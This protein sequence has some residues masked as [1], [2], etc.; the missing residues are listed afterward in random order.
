MRHMY[1]R[2][3]LISISLMLGAVA[4]GAGENPPLQPARAAWVD[5]ARVTA[6]ESEPGS[7]LVHGRTW[8]EQRFSPLDQIDRS[9]VQELGLAWAYMTGTLRGLEAT[10]LAVDGVLYLT[11]SWSVVYAL[12]AGT[13]RELWRYDPQVPRRI[14][15]RACCDVVNRGVALWKGRVYLATLDGRLVALDAATGKLAWEVMTVDPEAD[16]TIT[17]APRIVK[18]RV[19]IGNS[20]GE[21]GVRGY[22][23][24]YDAATG[25]RLWR[26]YTVPASTTG[27]F[28]HEEL[29]L[30]ATTWSPDS[31]WET[32]LG[33]TVW[34]AMAYDPELDLLYVGVGNSSPYDRVLRSPGGGDNL[35]LASIL[36]VKPET[37]RLVWHYQT[38]PGEQWDYTATQPMILAELEIA[39][40]ERKV[41]MQAPKNGF[42]YLLDRATG[43]LLSAEKIGYASWATH[44]DMQTGRPVE[45]EEASWSK[46]PR[47]VAPGPPGVHN[48]HP[49]SYSPRTG[50]VY[51]PTLDNAW[52]YTPLPGFRHQPGDFNTA[53]DFH[54]LGRFVKYYIPW[55]SPSH[56][57]AWDPVR[58]K[59]VWRVEFDHPANGGVLSTAGDLVF[60]GNGNTRFAAYDAETGEKLWESPVGIGILA[61]PISYAVDGVQH[62]AVLAGIGG[63]PSLNRVA[64]PYLN[65]GRLLVYKL[66]GSAPLPP[67]KPR[68][69]GVVDAPPLP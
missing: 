29:A 28:E 58:A 12:D 37:G 49:M 27:P 3:L 34:D 66:G 57:T 46:E 41:L 69:A 40:R 43:E 22:F 51:V 55:C 21:Y 17:G 9:N 68:P 23:G 25:E 5:A 61:P 60:Q 42:F 65:E 16:Y 20:G 64:V 45:R 38:T 67:V 33:G 62:I 13:G 31:L 6:A 14:G 53:E 44:V 39:G 56:L 24:A 2:S 8:S 48:W 35:F 50:L 18:G 7:W 47:W 59:P 4:A 63:T 54:A 1:V 52:L 26:F 19:I 36:A 11:G 10:P 32:G 30:A 15:R